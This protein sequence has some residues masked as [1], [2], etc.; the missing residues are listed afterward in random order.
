MSD[1]TNDENILDQSPDPSL[2]GQVGAIN[3]LWA[4]VEAEVSAA[5]FSLF[6]IDDLEFIILLGRME[7]I[8]KLKKLEQ[9]LKHRNDKAR[10]NIA[11]D[12]IRTWKSYVRTET[13]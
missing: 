7:I 12:L 8:P 5:L 2:L 10:E 11:L 3:I 1:P 6:D 4:I 9:I 13:P